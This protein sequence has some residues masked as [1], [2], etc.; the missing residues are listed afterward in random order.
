MNENSIG[1]NNPTVTFN[2]EM[3]TSAIDPQSIERA[4]LVMERKEKLKKMVGNLENLL[5]NLASRQTA[6]GELI[7][8]SEDSDISLSS[9]ARR[10]LGR[11]VC[12]LA[13]DTETAIGLLLD[14]DSEIKE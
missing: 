13:D 12:G 14:L 6:I 3:L 2:V 8:I 1:A 7:G 5:L 9:D 11:I 10:G 4:R